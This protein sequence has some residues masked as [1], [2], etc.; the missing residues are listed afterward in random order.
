MNEEEFISYLGGFFDGD[1]SI[2]IS[3]NILTVNFSQSEKSILDKINVFYSGIF[4]FYTRTTKEGNRT[5]FSIK[6]T[7][8][9]L[10]PVLLDLEK[11]C[12][13]KNAQVKKGIEF[14]QYVGK[15]GTTNEKIN[16]ENE[17]KKMN[18]D[19]GSYDKPYEKLNEKYGIQYIAGLFDSDGHVGIYERG[20]KAHITQ[21]SDVKLLELIGGFYDGSHVQDGKLYFTKTKIL[22]T[23]LEDILPCIVYKKKQVGKTLQ[24][25]YS[26]D[27]VERQLMKKQVKELKMV[28]IDVEG[29]K[30]YIQSLF[31]DINENYT[32]E[33]LLLYKK[34]QEITTVKNVKS[35]DDKIYND[36]DELNIVP[37][38]VFC[39]DKSKNKLWLYLRNKTSSIPFTGS[40]GRYIRI[41]V[42]DSKSGKYIG[43]MS[44]GSDL[45]G[46][47][48]R[49]NYIKDNCGGSREDYL[50]NIANLSCCVPLQPFGYNTN[51]GKLL[52]SLA[53]SREV[54]E[55]W[56]KKYN[57]P[58]L[59][60][61]SMSINGKS[62]LYDR[63]PQFKCVGYTKGA[64]AY[65]IP[66]EI[67]SVCKTIHTHAGLSTPR[68]GPFMMMKDLL[69]YLKLPVN[70]L[71]HEKRKGYYFGWLFST[72]FSE[73][74]D[75]EELNST[76]EISQW[77]ANR[78]A[79]KRFYRL[80]NEDLLK[81]NIQLYN[82]DD[83]VF[84]S[85]KYYKF[86]CYK[87]EDHSKKERVLS[88]K[89]V[90]KYKDT[91][92][93]KRPL[94]IRRLESNPSIYLEISLLKG[95]KTSQEV[96]DIVKVKHD[97]IIPRNDISQFWSGKMEEYL[98]ANVK[99]TDEYN[100]M[101]TC[102][103]KRVYNKEKSDTWR[104]AISSNRIKR[105]NFTEDQ[106][107]SILKDKMTS[108]SSIECGKK[109]IGKN[110]GCLKRGT[111]DKIW[112]GD[113]KP[114]DETS[115][116]N[117]DDIITHKRAKK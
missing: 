105:R 3:G 98:S 59:A 19:K 20:V 32:C 33:D 41:L 115:V 15:P 93:D 99:K 116:E 73:N 42:K 71:S 2:Y 109:Y 5:Q 91:E 72:K 8:K 76:S 55:Y 23:F 43:V 26:T 113:T 107:L 96:S 51:G 36:F 40:I 54:F 114:I 10:Y 29:Y 68:P 58:L 74:Y 67:T 18:S 30:N 53:F 103:K 79:S 25:L 95:K 112:N 78:W 34:H 84:S 75:I 100:V 4:N 66:H 63:L 7:G 24:Y 21:T 57:S 31:E 90:D 38:L 64:S 83:P 101:I 82:V 35:Y 45:Y 88:R 46:L 49:D 106:L 69:S 52:A 77:W 12:I 92:K 14:L 108:V 28:D 1:G 104:E 94:I 102:D 89:G 48:V 56:F 17:V 60:I 22:T 65:H 70:L 50:Q 39:E 11:S 87:I 97:I 117:Y 110:G 47:S 44:L 85:I 16:I 61:S 6:K 80:K 111:I 86:P 27:D 9:E 81:K 13:I 62:I 37:E